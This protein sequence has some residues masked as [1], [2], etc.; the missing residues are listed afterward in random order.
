MSSSMTP[1]GNNSAVSPVPMD[2]TP[3]NAMDTSQNSQASHASPQ[4]GSTSTPSATAAKFNP[5][6]QAVLEY[7][8]SKGMGS[9]VLELQEK[10]K[11]DKP[12]SEAN[13]RLKLDDKADPAA[14]SSETSLKVTKEQLEQEDDEARNQRATLTKATGGGFGYDRDA[15]AP[16]V[17]WGVPDT[18]PPPKSTVLSTE[19]DPKSGSI[20]SS[21]LGAQ[22]ARAYLDAFCALQ[23]WVLT[24]PD[25]ELGSNSSQST[26]SLIGR[27]RELIRQGQDDSSKKVSLSSF[28]QSLVTPTQST[29]TK[30]SASGRFNLPPSAKPELLA[31]TFALWV[32]T[33]CELL[34]V[35]MVTTAH[36]LRDAFKPIYEPLYGE[37]TKD[38]N[39]C[40]STDDVVKL[41]KHNTDHMEALAGLKSILLQIASLQLR[42]EEVSQAQMTDPQQQ[43]A[44]KAKIKEYAQNI[45]MLQQKH[46]EL[47]Q[48]ASQAF[49]HMN[50]LPFL[51]RARAVRWQLT[52]ST[53]SYG[54]LAQFL[55]NS[56][57]QSSLLAMSTL[58][59]TKCEL[60][61]EQRDPVPFT[62][63]VVL[64]DNIDKAQPSI[65]E[66]AMV[67]W[68]A[69][70]PP[71]VFK[72][73]TSTLLEQ[74]Q[75]QPSSSEQ[76][77]P[78]FPKY[79]LEE[80]YEDEKSALR[81]KRTVE[82][83]RAL[84]VNGF[85]RLEALERK[86]EFDAMDDTDKKRM[87]SPDSTAENE[88]NTEDSVENPA[89]QLSDPFD[90]SILMSTLCANTDSNPSASMRKRS[91]SVAGDPH[92]S[93]RK[94]T[95]SS[96]LWEEAGVGITCA[97]M[98][99]PDGRRV[100]TGCDDAAVRIWD[101]T[102]AHK[103]E[104]GST[105]EVGQVLL[106]HKNG[107]PVFDVSWNRDGRSL[108]SCGGDGSIRLWDTLAQGPFGEVV[109]E[110]LTVNSANLT[111]K[112]G[113]DKPVSSAK[114]ALNKA[115]NALNQAKLQPE[116][117]VPGLK[118]ENAP[119]TSG[120]ALAVYR[121]HAQ[122]TPVWSVT[123]SPS[124]YYFASAGGDATARL[125]TTDRPVP[126]RLFTGHTSNSVHSVEFHPNCNYI[127][128]GS[129]DKTARL[130]DIQTGQCVRLLNG[131]SSGIHKVKVDP[132][133][134]LAAGADASG[135]VHLWDL[136]T[137]KKITEFR[138]PTAT[139]TADALRLGG[140]ST[141]GMV[142]AMSFS[143]C[144]SALAT[145]G[146]DQC[147]RIWDIKQALKRTSKGEMEFARRSYPTRLTM[148]MDLHYTKRN[149]LLSV[150]KYISAVPLG[151][152]NTD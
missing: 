50:N 33:Y 88:S 95:M 118:E 99:P 98:C 79:H 142:H 78:P 13:K 6:D 55:N 137:G 58:L 145:G 47:S 120:A 89:F 82:F 128:T 111:G 14:G 103:D 115:T 70:V 45:A 87:T 132:S 29:P 135:S 130:W 25:D 22:E 101:L 93:T 143:A 113:A 107:F 64:D 151:N 56:A 127:L 16:I 8:R 54:L 75:S 11:Q 90:A 102:K 114:E 30:G 21:S 46:N 121:G 43:Q 44:Q 106:G 37:A 149:L 136:G 116:M 41:N 69:P 35:G 100:A 76:G 17:Q 131:C 83:N 97:K 119:Y 52:L 27:A 65:N 12:S 2:T 66:T 31:V 57:M 86:R 94:P 23:L 112:K 3:S 67:N 122:N 24:L 18:E 40:Q 144:G 51:R 141:W 63:S 73:A 72:D 110:P 96:A 109:A 126:V 10:L 42:Q 85:R 38:L 59:Q 117:N 48:R 129:E 39:R 92:L 28:V 108:L 148:V 81:D 49:D 36:V 60:H 152:S 71:S 1:P 104:N 77:R 5:T 53:T 61:V 105:H 84:L 146:D 15:A 26:S 7:L 68:A 150:G 91:N 138:A 147:V 80:E 133:G 19:T 9:A 34:E 4:G 139:R 124:G 134:Q 32:H 125:W 140:Q 74:S 62:P 123:F 20:I